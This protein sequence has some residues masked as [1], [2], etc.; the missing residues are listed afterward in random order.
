MI[1][2]TVAGGDRVAAE[3]GLWAGGVAEE[4]RDWLCLI[5]GTLAEADTAADEALVAR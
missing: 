1:S 3:V 5:S 2:V 4:I